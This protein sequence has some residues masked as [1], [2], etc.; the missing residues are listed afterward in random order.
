MVI[1]KVILII[2]L[3]LILAFILNGIE[4]YHKENSLIRLSFA[5]K[6]GKLRLPI[7]S[8]VNNGRVFNFLIDSGA[9][10]SIIDTPFLEQ[11][12]HKKLEA[13]GSC[14]VQVIRYKTVNYKNAV[15]SYNNI[16]KDFKKQTEDNYVFLVLVTSTQ[17]NKQNIVLKAT[18]EKEDLKEG[19]YH[20]KTTMTQGKKTETRNNVLGFRLSKLNDGRWGL[21]SCDKNGNYPGEVYNIP[22]TYDAKQQLWKGHRKL[23]ENVSKNPNQP[24]IETATLD[25]TMKVNLE[26]KEPVLIIR[27][28]TEGIT[29]K[30]GYPTK[31]KID[32]KFEGKWVS[33]LKG[34]NLH[35]GKEDK[36]I[37]LE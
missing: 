28:K 19:I 29:W 6:L 18:L 23:K 27:F 36:V 25:C 11:M 9:T 22:L 13:E 1:L 7:V 20:G 15:S 31:E 17:N 5:D 2:V 3:V 30:W 4:D 35:A 14:R 26:G 8:L 12:S 10:Y 33:E 24:K 37:I 32:I 21:N 16:I 34:R